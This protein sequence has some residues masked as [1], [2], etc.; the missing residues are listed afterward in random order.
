MKPLVALYLYLYGELLLSSFLLFGTFATLA[1]KD[2]RLH[3]VKVSKNTYL[4]TCIGLAGK[5]LA[6]FGLM[7][8]W[9]TSSQWAGWNFAE[10][11]TW[12]FAALRIGS[13]AGIIGFSVLLFD[14]ERK[15]ISYRLFW[16][17]SAVWLVALLAYNCWML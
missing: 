15:R 11:W 5:N 7:L 3:A 16:T 6:L 4:W 1:V 9:L 17:L 8:S 2:F 12:T 14:L 13:I 10:S